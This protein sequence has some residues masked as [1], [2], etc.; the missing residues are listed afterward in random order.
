MEAVIPPFAFSKVLDFIGIRGGIAIAFGLALAFVMWRA[1]DLSEGKRKA[2]DALVASETRHAVTTASLDA[3]EG[4]LADLVEAGQLREE[5]RNKA[6][7]DVAK[8]TAE[9]RKSAEDFDITT[10]E[11]L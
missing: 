6:L 9:L 7:E 5:A 10:A 11:G 3:L 8:E 1:D 2:E 4:K